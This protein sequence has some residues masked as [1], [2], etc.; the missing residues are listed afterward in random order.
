MPDIVC[1]RNRPA[2]LRYDSD[3]QH[4]FAI[5]RFRQVVL[6]LVARGGGKHRRF[7]VNTQSDLVFHSTFMKV[8]FIRQTSLKVHKV[9]C[10]STRLEVDLSK[11]TIRRRSTVA[12]VG[13]YSL[14]VIV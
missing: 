8:P 3:P 11:T 9:I 10:G 4:H 14:S 1:A 12:H 2:K 5:S 7:R 6:V 13:R